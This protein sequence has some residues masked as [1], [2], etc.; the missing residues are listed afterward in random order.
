MPRK[1]VA[2]SALHLEN[3]KQ[4]VARTFGK[5]IITKPD[6]VALS[7]QVQ[8]RT[9]VYLSESTLRR[10]FGLIASPSQPSLQTLDTLAQF[11]GC[12]N[13]YAFINQQFPSGASPLAPDLLQWEVIRSKARRIS[14][15]SLQRIKEG[16][17]LPYEVTSSRPSAQ[18]LLQQFAYSPQTALCFYA[19]SGAGKSTLLAHWVEQ[20]QAHTEDIIWLVSGNALSQLLQQGFSLESWLYQSLGVSSTADILQHFHRQPTERPGTMWLV[21]DGFSFQQIRSDECVNFYRSLLSFIQEVHTY[22]WFKVILSVQVPLWQQVINPLRQ[23]LRQTH[24]WFTV[25]E[26]GNLVKGNLPPLSWNEIEQIIR[27]YHTHYPD[28]QGQ[29]LT[30]LPLHTQ[31]LLQNPFFLQLYLTADH[32]SSPEAIDELSLVELF[33]REQIER[34]PYAYEKLHLIQRIISL[35]TQHQLTD[36]VIKTELFT[37]D[38]STTAYEE[39]LKA[40]ILEESLELR[41]LFDADKMVRFA[42]TKVLAYTVV[43]Y[44]LQQHHNRVDIDLAKQLGRLFERSEVL[45]EILRWLIL[46]GFRE[47]NVEFLSQFFDLDFLFVD[48]TYNDSIIFHLV[49][50]LGIQLR[51]HAELREKLWPIYAQHPLGRAYYFEFFVD[52]D[53]LVLHHYE[54]LTIYAQHKTTPEARLFVNCL[55]FLKGFLSGNRNECQAA[56]QIITQIEPDLSIHP[57]PLG[58]R[59]A[60]LLLYEHYYGS[61]IGAEMIS[62]LHKIEE[63][64]PELGA[65]GRHLPTYHTIISEALIWCEHYDDA[66]LVLKNAER[67]YATDETF[68]GASFH[69]QLL[70]NLANIQVRLGKSE[71]AKATFGRIKP[72]LFDVHSRQYNLVSYHLLESLLFRTEGEVA[73][74]KQTYKKAESAANMLKYNGLIE[75]IFPLYQC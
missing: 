56:C 49:I 35:I 47:K 64:M 59:F 52:I 28:R 31:E 45:P 23:Q 55:L 34:G 70:L 71:Q 40:G 14:E 75:N 67:R 21:M 26:V 37:A 10:F 22:P 46:L 43:S 3:L 19:P 69:H 32:F 42:N 7:E 72:Y 27:A 38:T 11:V 9:G 62:H 5:P 74:A 73:K 66:N 20:Q 57:T 54:G 8:Q 51:R 65:L 13:W 25:A 12:D 36:S 4:Q 63:Q 29:D 6:C 16:L 30:A 33:V 2:I 15:I 1:K 41:G 53:Y 39:L 24:C 58:R 18:E 68:V 61:G 60:C 48:K 50:T 17:G 44:Y